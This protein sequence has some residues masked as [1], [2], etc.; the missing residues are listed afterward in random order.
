L[1]WPGN[2]AN[3]LK[4]D[5]DFSGSVHH[6]M[7]TAEKLN[8]AR[9]LVDVVAHS[10]GNR[11]M[12]ETMRLLAAD[13]RGVDFGSFVLMAAAVNAKDVDPG[14]TLNAPA[15]MPRL[16]AIFHS[17][18]DMVLAIAAPAGE[19]PDRRGLFSR[20]SGPSWQAISMPG[21]STRRASTA[22]AIAA[23]RA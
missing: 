19:T 16:T 20:S 5:V 1:H 8:G 11:V 10:L 7:A 2:A 13:N 12:L 21:G 22:S 18:S 9:L 17:T 15:L 23:G 14:A 3:A 4:S 6:A